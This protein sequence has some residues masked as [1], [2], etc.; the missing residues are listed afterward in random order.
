[1]FSFP[2]TIEETTTAQCRTK[3]IIK[4]IE[5]KQQNLDIRHQKPSVELTKVEVSGLINQ[6]IEVVQGYLRN[7]NLNSA[8]KK[9]IASIVA[10][11]K[12]AK[13]SAPDIALKSAE[14]VLM[15]HIAQ[16]SQD[17][18][19]LEALSAQTPQQP[20]L[21]EEDQ[22]TLVTACNQAIHTLSR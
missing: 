13:K 22:A 20:Q 15:V 11:L 7:K 2:K 17:S 4:V 1:M 16:I 6:A 14:T 18:A 8:A 19:V 9:N 12:K 3:S 10:S 5:W 21:T